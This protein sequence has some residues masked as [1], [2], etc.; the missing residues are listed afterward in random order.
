MCV[1]LAQRTY[2]ISKR[3]VIRGN[4]EVT[5]DFLQKMAE[6]KPGK[7][8][9]DYR[10][11]E[12]ARK[13]QKI[14]FIEKCTVRVVYPQ[15]L[16]IE[17]DERKP[18]A[19]CEKDTKLYWMDRS[20]VL[21]KRAKISERTTPLFSGEKP[22]SSLAEQI[23]SQHPRLAPS[24]EKYHRLPSGRWDVKITQG[25]WVRLPQEQLEAALARLEKLCQKKNFLPGFGV[26]DLR[27]PGRVVYTSKIEPV[28]EKPA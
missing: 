16:Y 1:S 14:Q 18:Y 6:F 12:I 28:P 22:D 26:I 24:I 3:L 11:E 15:T 19:C 8:L 17:V 23:R 21:L 10:A 27:V 5:Y 13:I 20:G 2:C 9:F 4:Q 25:Y 7:P